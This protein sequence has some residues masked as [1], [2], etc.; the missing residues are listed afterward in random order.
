MAL[1]EEKLKHET[2]QGSPL[3]PLQQVCLTLSFFSNASFQHVAGQVTG[4]KKSCAARTIWRVSEALCQ[5]SKDIIQFPGEAEMQA[6]SE[7]IQRRFGIPNC[8]LGT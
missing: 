7:I 5:I 3:S 8:P 2:L 1:V 4:V 6:D